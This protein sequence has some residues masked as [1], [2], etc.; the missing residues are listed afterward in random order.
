MTDKITPDAIQNNNIRTTPTT[1]TA[2]S[3]VVISGWFC[4]PRTEYRLRLNAIHAIV[5]KQ[6]SMKSKRN[7]I[8]FT[9]THSCTHEHTHRRTMTMC[10]RHSI[11]QWNFVWYSYTLVKFSHFDSIFGWIWENA[12]RIQHLSG[13]DETYT[14]GWVSER[15]NMEYMSSIKINHK[16]FYSTVSV[17]NV[18]G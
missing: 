6:R 12:Q 4:Y 18:S 14:T 7:F 15:K 11:I 3:R 9:N 17:N 10:V 8:T 2:T 16:T 13:N 5:N 1:T